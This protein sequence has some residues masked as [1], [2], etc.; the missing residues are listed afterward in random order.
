M[1]AALQTTDASE[2]NNTGPLGGPVIMINPEIT[3]Q[4]LWL[5]ASEV[6]LTVYD[7]TTLRQLN[8]AS[9]PCGAASWQYGVPQIVTN[10]SGCPAV[11]L[12]IAGFETDVVRVDQRRHWPLLYIGRIYRRLC[13]IF[14][15]PPT[16]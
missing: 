6:T 13:C 9:T 3:S 4:S 2:Q 16:E 5:Q 1:P 7:K 12:V 10:S 11:G 8:A 15:P 14:S